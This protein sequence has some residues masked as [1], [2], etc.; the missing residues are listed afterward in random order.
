MFGPLGVLANAQMIENNTMADVTLLKD[1]ISVDPK[2]IFL[3]AASTSG[4]S[5]S[6]SG[7]NKQL[8]LNPYLYMQKMENDRIVV[9][10]VILVDHVGSKNNQQSRYMIQLP[11]SF[12]IPELSSMDAAKTQQFERLINDGFQQLLTALQN[13]TTADVV[14]EPDATVSS[15]FLTP[16]FKSELAGK[17]IRQD[18]TYTWFRTF[19]G[20]F[21]LL[22][23]DVVVKKTVVKTKTKK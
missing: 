18:Q 5:I 17:I 4:I 15:D 13:E 8:R 20:V 1:K 10:S 19:N 23:S 9:A 11:T 22:N 12:T 7:S 16:R 21:G 14:T 6:T 2:T 3:A